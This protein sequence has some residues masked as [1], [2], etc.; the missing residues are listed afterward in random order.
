MAPSAPLY[1]CYGCHGIMVIVRCV[2]LARLWAGRKAQRGHLGQRGRLWTRALSGGWRINNHTSIFAWESLCADG[3][4][5]SFSKVGAGKTLRQHPFAGWSY[6]SCWS[7]LGE[8]HLSWALPRGL[9]QRLMTI[10]PSD[11][12][13]C[14]EDVGPDLIH[15]IPGS[16]L[17][18]LD[19]GPLE[20]QDAG[21]VVQAGVIHLLPDA[22]VQVLH[23]QLLGRLQHAWT[24]CLNSDPTW[25]EF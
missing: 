5:G 14:Y 3:W 10:Q 7:K 6:W 22:V 16:L 1:G 25:L 18:V 9:G 8:F 12:L 13:L 23:Q 15:L 17:A 24:L 2:L 21:S 11:S 20:V 4:P 19:Q